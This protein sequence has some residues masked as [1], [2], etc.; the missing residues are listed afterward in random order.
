MQKLHH[1][2]P[3][4]SR[5]EIASAKLYF[6]QGKMGQ[7]NLLIFIIGLN[8]GLMCRD[9]VS[10]KVNDIIHQKRPYIIEHNTGK[11]RQ[12][13]L[14]NIYQEI[15]KYIV[16]N[17][18]SDDNYLF[19]SRSHNV[20]S[21]LSVNGF[22]K[23]VKRVGRQLGRNDLDT[24]TMRKTFGY[25]YYQTTHD[26]STLRIIFHHNSEQFTK[27]YIGIFNTEDNKNFLKDFKL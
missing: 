23:V 17:N 12:L 7:R 9:I 8:T 13:D 22:Y 1:I 16:D 24:H 15:Q 6:K 19:P 10:L 14:T 11:K 18:L 26:I 21:H 25:F 27:N 4:H 2:K 20:S 5:Q 3:L